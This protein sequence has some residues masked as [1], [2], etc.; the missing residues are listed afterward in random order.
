MQEMSFMLWLSQICILSLTAFQQMTIRKAWFSDSGDVI[1]WA[2]RRG[3]G[4]LGSCFSTKLIISPSHSLLIGLQVS[5]L[6]SQAPESHSIPWSIL[7][8]KIHKIPEFEVGGRSKF[9]QGGWVIH[10]ISLGSGVLQ[11][12]PMESV[13]V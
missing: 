11:R 12:E 13:S 7:H 9:P 6:S 8:S 2:Y 10:A 5:I 4:G 3:P 1:V